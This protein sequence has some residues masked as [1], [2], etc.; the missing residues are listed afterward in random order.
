[1]PR[2]KPP[3]VPS[4]LPGGLV[5]VNPATLPGLARVRSGSAFRYRL[6]GGPWLRD[7]GEIARILKITPDTVTRHRKAGQEH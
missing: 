7:A 2:T 4:R 5:Y 1:M 3:D 6:P